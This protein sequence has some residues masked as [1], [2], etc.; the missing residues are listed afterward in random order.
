MLEIRELTVEFPAA[1]GVARVVEGASLSV[2]RGQAVGVVGESG[3]GKSVTALSVLRL[4]PPEARIA[5]GEVLFEGDDLL[6]L[7]PAA[8]RRIRG[9]RVGI[10]FQ[11]PQSALNPTM[12]V[13]EQVA[14]GLLLHRSVTRAKAHERVQALLASLGIPDPAMCCRSYPYQLSG[15][16]RQR[17]LL[18]M[19]LICEPQL[20]IADEPTTALDVTL[21]A[22]VI[23]L[24][25]RARLES[26][27]GLLLVTHDLALVGQC[28]SELTVLYAGQVVEQGPVGRCFS[29]PG[30]PYTAAL[31]ATVASLDAGPGES[32]ALASI[33]G[34][35][36]HPLAY[37]SGCRFAD[38]CP[39]VERDCRARPPALAPRESN[40]RAERRRGA[41]PA[42]S[43]DPASDWTV[44]CIHPLP[45]HGEDG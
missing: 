29:A 3:C 26:G 35:V 18:A 33:P 1:D 4:L 20:L 41:G 5:A 45:L 21:Q 37:P 12:Q 19:A 13:G 30:H 10:V 2:A 32:G 38:R 43:Q 16:M 39:R 7:D 8:L 11:E 24:I 9:D 23:E 25:T 31:R 27:M 28:C 6:K 34:V 22:Q 42:G 40:K 44:R 36:P 14:E 17:V 15:G